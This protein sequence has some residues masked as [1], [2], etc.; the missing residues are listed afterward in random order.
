MPCNQKTKPVFT[1]EQIEECKKCKHASK[2]KVWCCLFGVY[3]RGN[4]VTPKIKY[5]S[6]LR[7]GAGFSKALYR[8]V[9]SGLKQRSK[10]EQEKCKAICKK[11]I[12]FV[13][14]TK[15]G[16]RCRLCGCCMDLKTRWETAHCEIGKW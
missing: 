15:V 9:R 1:P 2:R 6:K 10:E 3:I 7:M 13:P 8:H 4:I 12:H 11:C 5:P 14:V 16:P